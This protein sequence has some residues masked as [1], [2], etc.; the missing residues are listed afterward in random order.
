MP[1][2]EVMPICKTWLYGEKMAS[3]KNASCEEARCCKAKVEYVIC[4]ALVELK[5]L[6]AISN[7]GVMG[8]DRTIVDR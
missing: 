6:H 3:S 8:E 5:K 4:V 2:L 1:R 7:N